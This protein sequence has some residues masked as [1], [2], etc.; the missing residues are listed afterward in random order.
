M[1]ENANAMTRGGFA[2]IYSCFHAGSS[3]FSVFVG[4]VLHQLLKRFHV[5]GLG[6]VRKLMPV[7]FES[8]LFEERREPESEATRPG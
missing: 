4:P 8:N 6:F 5:N 1:A 2:N 7:R 3:R